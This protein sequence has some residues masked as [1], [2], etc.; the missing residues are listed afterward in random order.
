MLVREYACGYVDV[1]M[2]VGVVYCLWI[3]VN[4]V[5]PALVMLTGSRHRW[6]SSRVR[7]PASGTTLLASSPRLAA[8]LSSRA[9][10]RSA[11][12]RLPKERVRGWAAPTGTQAGCVCCMFAVV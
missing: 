2:D 10:L 1:D 5:H 3:W 8:G 4:N 11:V 9:A 12:P 7:I 6:P